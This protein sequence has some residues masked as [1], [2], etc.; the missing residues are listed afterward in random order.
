MIYGKVSEKAIL[1]EGWPLVRDSTIL[2]CKISGWN[3]FE[4]DLSQ[5]PLA[6]PF[7]KVICLKIT[8]NMY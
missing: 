3:F 2:H 7:Q 1:N 6:S 5:G 4:T 8:R